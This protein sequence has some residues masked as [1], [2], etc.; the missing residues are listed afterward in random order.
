MSEAVFCQNMMS[1]L[2]F[3]EDFKCVPLHVDTTSG[4]SL[5]GNHTYKSHTNHVALTYFCVREIIEEGH[6]RIH[7]IPTDKDPAEMNPDFQ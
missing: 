5:A 6:M 7:Y 1:E 4:L 2:G 3:K